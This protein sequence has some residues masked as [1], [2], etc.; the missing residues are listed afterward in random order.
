MNRFYINGRPLTLGQKIIG[1]A[2]GLLTLVG[3]F[4]VI[5]VIW[6]FLLA[7]LFVGIGVIWWRT[8]HLRALF[9][10]QQQMMD[11]A[12]AQMHSEKSPEE[13]AQSGTL[14]EGEYRKVDE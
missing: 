2:V 1:G 8:R 14:F 9:K 11:E 5:A 12:M 13:R 7:L 4:M 3:L 6:P 10:A